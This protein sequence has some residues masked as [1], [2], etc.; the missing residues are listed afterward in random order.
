MIISSAKTK[1]HCAEEVSLLLRRVLEKEDAISKDAE[2]FWVISLKSNNCVICIEL[3]SIGSLNNT[4]THPREVF[5]RSIINGAASIIV[6]HNHPSGETTPS[7]ED[8]QFTK[9][10]KEVGEI[11]GIKLLDHIIIGENYFSFADEGLL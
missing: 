6:G 1:V 8:R 10:L 3:V 2:H 4:C 11:V 7:T 9:R 5:R